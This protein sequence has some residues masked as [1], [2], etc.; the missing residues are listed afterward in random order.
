[1]PIWDRRCEEMK[2]NIANHEGPTIESIRNLIEF[3]TKFCSDALRQQ[4]DL[5]LKLFP[6]GSL[7]R[8]MLA[9]MFIKATNGVGDA[10]TVPYFKAIAQ[11]M[12]NET[13]ELYNMTLYKLTKPLFI[14]SLF[15]QY[16]KWE[17]IHILCVI[18]L[19]ILLIIMKENFLKKRNSILDY[20]KWV[21]RVYLYVCGQRSKRKYGYL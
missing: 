20:M 15:C 3:S 6:K 7:K 18:W 5:A 14:A 1:M 12:A 8:C 13:D 9:L 19:N 10:N 11:R 4:W 21:Q 17:K 2:S 16:S